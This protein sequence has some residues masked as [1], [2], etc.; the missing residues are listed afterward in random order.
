MCKGPEVEKSLGGEWLEDGEPR[1]QAMRPE[2]SGL[3]QAGSMTHEQELRLSS[4][5]EASEGF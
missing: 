4:R 3:A 5:W 1:G 2:G